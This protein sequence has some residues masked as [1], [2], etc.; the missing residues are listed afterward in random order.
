MI[1]LEVATTYAGFHS[2]GGKHTGDIWYTTSMCTNMA[3]M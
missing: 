3:N 2:D 1:K